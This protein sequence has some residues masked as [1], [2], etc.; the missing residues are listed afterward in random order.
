MFFNRFQKCIWDLIE[1]PESSQTANIVSYISM[2]FVVVS[3]IGMSLNTLQGLKVINNDEELQN[4]PMLE[5]IEAVCIAWFTLE[6]FL[7][8]EC[9]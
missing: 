9:F 4:N 1:H 7:R 2:M 5:Q 8:W 6:Y 3:T